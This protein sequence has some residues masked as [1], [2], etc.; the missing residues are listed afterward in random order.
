MAPQ[1]PS[2]AALSPETEPH[3]EQVRVAEFHIAKSATDEGRAQK[4]FPHPSDS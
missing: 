1:H 3:S 4:P 2:F